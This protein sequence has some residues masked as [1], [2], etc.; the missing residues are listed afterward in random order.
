MKKNI[1]LLGYIGMILVVGSF[2][3]NPVNGDTFHILNLIGAILSAVYG[4]LIKSKP[5]WIMNVCIGIFDILH[6]LNIELVQL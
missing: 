4:F 5:V 3:F 6:L 2:L 1:E